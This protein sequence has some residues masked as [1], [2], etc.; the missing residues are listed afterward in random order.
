MDGFLLTLDIS[1]GE[2]EG[3]DVRKV[4]GG[5][6]LLILRLS[7]ELTDLSEDLLFESRLPSLRRSMVCLKSAFYT[8]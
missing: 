6:D 2:N 4:G 7:S 8:M 1:G 3:K 5:L